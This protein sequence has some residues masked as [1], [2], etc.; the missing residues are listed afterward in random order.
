M[1]TTLTILIVLA[2]SVLAGCNSVAKEF[3]TVGFQEGQTLRY[4]FVSSRDIEVDWDPAKSKS[5]G[6][7]SS[8]AKSSE[9]MEMVISYTPIKIE[10]Y[11][12][13]TIKATCES[14]KIKRSKGPKKDAVKSLTGKSFI[15]TVDSAGKIEDYSQLDKLIR[16]IGEKAFRASRRGGRVKEPDMISDFVASQW[17]LWDSVSSIEESAKGVA[18]GQTWTSKLSVPAPMVLRQ[19]REVTYT[20]DEIRQTEKGKLAVFRSSYSHY[21]S[22]PPYSWPKPYVGEFGVSGMFGFLKRYRILELQGQGEELFNIDAGRIELSSQKYKM[23]LNASLPMIGGKIPITIEQ[24]LTMQ[25]L[26]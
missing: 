1:K 3:L 14:V 2:L 21:K 25:L 4:R 17:F 18:V 20:L 16:E 22:V 23:L 15:I 13:A 10:P 24:N 6:G 26:E 11:G 19:A 8:V 7:K 9:S 5:G 12:A